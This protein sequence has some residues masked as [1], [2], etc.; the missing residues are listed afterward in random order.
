[1]WRAGGEGGPLT[2]ASL[3]HCV[4]TCLEKQKDEAHSAAPAPKHKDRSYSGAQ[5]PVGGRREVWDR[6]AAA[7]QHRGSL[8]CDKAGTQR[9]SCMQ[10]F[11][12]TPRSLGR[13][14]GLWAA[15]GPG[16]LPEGVGEAQRAAIT[17]LGSD[18][19]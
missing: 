9:C 18:P 10:G 1:M 15:E 4:K 19:S 16:P 11:P 7:D 17:G 12:G 3:A 8:R 13:P 14:V 2:C 5:E 6:Q